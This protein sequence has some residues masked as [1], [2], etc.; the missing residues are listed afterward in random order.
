MTQDLFSAKTTLAP[1]GGAI[2]GA[3]GGQVSLGR[4]GFARLDVDPQAAR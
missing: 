3:A 2:H 4:L 1:I